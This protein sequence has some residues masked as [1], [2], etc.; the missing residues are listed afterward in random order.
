MPAPKRRPAP[1]AQFQAPTAPKA[2]SPGTTPAPGLVVD[3]FALTVL[4][5]DSLPAK[6][7]GKPKPLPQ[8]LAQ[9]LAEL[10]RRE[11]HVV[12]LDASKIDEDSFKSMAAILRSNR[13][14]FAG[15]NLRLTNGHVTTTGVPAIRVSLHAS[16]PTGA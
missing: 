7:G 10:L 14:L 2:A 3:P 16:K 5:T 13:H 15:Y 4:P 1:P 6:S 8:S 11:D 12:V 9:L